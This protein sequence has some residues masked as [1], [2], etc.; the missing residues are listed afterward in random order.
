MNASLGETDQISW[1]GY[2]SQND[3][4]TLVEPALMAML[5]LFQEKA[6]SIPMLKHG[7]KVIMAAV[8]KLNDDQIPVIACDQPIY[9][10]MKQIQWQCDTYSE[11]KVVVM[12]GGLHT[13]MTG[14]SVLGKLLDRSGWVEI[15]SEADVTTSGRAQ[16]ILHASHLKRTRII[17]EISHIVFSELKHR[18]YTESG[19][20]AAYNQCCSEKCTE[21]PNFFF[22]DL[23]L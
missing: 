4:S 1:A 22:W 7:F 12:L 23:I 17:H 2:F 16:S 14:W 19:S 9:A 5:P 8:K 15:L 11:E 13:E 10:L 21:S 6:A 18:A 3:S 20:E